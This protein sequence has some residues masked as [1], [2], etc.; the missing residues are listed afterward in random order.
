[1]NSLDTVEILNT[2][3][4][5]LNR[6]LAVYLSKAA[7]WTPVGRERSLGIL[8]EI[9]QNKLDM[10]DRIGALIMELGGVVSYG[11]FPMNFTALHDLS[12]DYLHDALVDRQAREV[13][14]IEGLASKLRFNPQA[15]ALALEALGESKA[16]LDMLREMSSAA[17]H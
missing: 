7:P 14:V 3:L 4:G 1:M 8:S 10:V 12:L 17:T 9:A 16:H 2:L 15:Q 11:E 5:V 6:S 13:K